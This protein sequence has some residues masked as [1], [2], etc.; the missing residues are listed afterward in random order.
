MTRSTSR[1]RRA[2]LAAFAVILVILAFGR[3][4][5]ASSTGIVNV[6]DAAD[7]EAIASSMSLQG[8]APFVYRP[9]VP[10]TVGLL[11]PDRLVLGFGIVCALAMF[12]T[13]YMVG[14]LSRQGEA[15]YLLAA[16]LFLNYQV[17][18][19]AA[20]PARLDIVVLAVQLAFVGLALERNERWFFAMLPLCALLKESMLLGLVALALLAFPRRR[21]LWA[22]LVA[23]GAG[24][25]AVHMLVRWMARPSASMPPYNDGLPTVGAMLEMAA[26]NLS[27]ST[28][29]SFGVAWGGLCF[30]ALYLLLG[31]ERDKPDGV[32]L[33]FTAFLLIFPVPLATDL[34]RAWFELLAPMVLFSILLRMRT[35]GRPSV[36]GSLGLALGASIVF[37]ATRLVAVEHLYLLVLQGR[38][39]PPAIAALVVA[40]SI[41]ALA[42]VFWRSGNPSVAAIPD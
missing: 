7:Y 1:R 42:L 9:L 28:A 19:S 27:A 2:V 26:T 10:L 37:Y 25:V 8:R 30:V 36:V 12:A 29:L 16:T 23:S 11:F 15:G 13:L 20:Y 21:D 41:A 32:L 34:H 4:Y 33:A 17:L 5:V 3:A 35:A 39:S 31:G 40:L 22:R 6:G 38:L 14:A 24:F 18:F